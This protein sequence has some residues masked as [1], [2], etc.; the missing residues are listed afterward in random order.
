M[1]ESRE[2][3]HAQIIGLLNNIES[4]LKEKN[5]EKA[6]TLTNILALLSK[7]DVERAV[8]PVDPDVRIALLDRVKRIVEEF[9]DKYSTPT[10]NTSSFVEEVR[11]LAEIGRIEPEAL[12][13]LLKPAILIMIKN[14]D[15]FLRAVQEFV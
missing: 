6:E 14:G 7:T 2:E 9:V 3:L 11:L 4:A 1:S 15:K 5:M 12:K 13:P 8:N 10:S